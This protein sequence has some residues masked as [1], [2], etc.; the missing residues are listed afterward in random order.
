MAF[1]F[2][3]KSDNNKNKKTWK[4]VYKPPKCVKTLFMFWKPLIDTLYIPLWQSKLEYDV[5]GINYI[6]TCKCK[7]ENIVIDRDNNVHI[8]MNY[9]ELTLE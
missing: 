6:I 3:K 4:A 1:K 8:K 5:Q 9:I 2:L 7:D